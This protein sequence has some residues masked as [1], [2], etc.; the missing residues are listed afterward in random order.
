MKISIA[1]A[2]YNGADY[3]QEQLDSFLAQTRRP[4][5]FVVVDD[6]SSDDTLKILEEFSKCAPFEVRIYRNEVNLGYAQN[7][8]RVLSFCTGDLIFLS[9]QDDIWFKE[10]IEKIYHFADEHP[11]ILLFMND[12]ELTLGD[13]K[14]LGLTKLGQTL[15][16]GLGDST[17]T[18]GCC[19]AIRNTFVQL[20]LP[21]PISF[22]VHD[23]WLNRLSLLLDVKKVIPQVM[24]YYRRH[25]YNTSNWLASRTTK[26]SPVDFI[27]AYKD[28]D[29][30]PFAAE[31][32][33]QL[34]LL[35]KRL[36]TSDAPML[37][38]ILMKD[39]IQEALEKIQIERKA[40]ESRLR[41][42]DYPRWRRWFS[43]AQFH[44]SGQY[45][46]FSGWK[47]LVKDIIRK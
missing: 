36:V 42:L 16:L 2:T 47:S 15:S 24:Q 44:Y 34:E 43:V 12:A 27:R 8:G 13:G 35:E 22:F 28:K 18:T 30:R 31:R 33:K 45:S 5:E 1:M 26:L 32:L 29:P 40:V 41:F 21:V 23:T 6:C 19:M 39:H 4:D 46:H 20:A 25:G 11:E 17:F 14:P 7:F 9:D 37:Q 10:K 38:G 3:L